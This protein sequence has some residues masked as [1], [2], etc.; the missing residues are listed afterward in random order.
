MKKIITV[1]SVL[2]VSACVSTELS[3]QNKVYN[4]LQD[5]RIRLY[6][7]NRR[8]S[9]MEIEINGKTEKITVGGGF[10]QALGSMLGV[11]GNESIG[12]PET[13]FSKD[14][15]AHSK[16]LSAIFFKEFVIPA[17]KEVKVTNSI[18]DVTNMGEYYTSTH[19]ITTTTTFK[20]CNGDVITF[21]AEAGKDYEVAPIS[22]NREC[23]VTV[24]EIK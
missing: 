21:I 19:R 1:L 12:M 9:S 8:P 3:T 22:S 20:G 7:Q 6:G 18:H 5:A 15:S 24:Y 10:G 2:A 13:E 17:G 23:G 14:P 16:L 4:N 11:K